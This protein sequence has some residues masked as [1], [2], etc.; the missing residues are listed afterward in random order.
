VVE[1]G[2]DAATNKMSSWSENDFLETLMPLLQQESGARK[3]SCP[4]VETL[5]AVVDGTAG[6]FIREAVA[7]HLEHCNSCVRLH[8]SILLFGKQ[9]SLE[10]SADWMQTEKRLDNWMEGYLR[11]Q[12]NAARRQQAKTVPE[13]LPGARPADSSFRWGKI[14]WAAGLAAVV[15]FALGAVFLYERT[16]TSAPAVQT[17]SNVATSA[18]PAQIAPPPLA[19]DVQAQSAPTAAPP[20][21]KIASANPVLTGQS[22][23]PSAENSPIVVAPVA[24]VTTAPVPTTPVSPQPR[25]ASGTAPLRSTARGNTYGAAFGSAAS[26]NTAHAPVPGPTP[27]GPAS[28][29]LDAGTTLMILL[30]AISPKKEDGSFVFRGTLVEPV[31]QGGAHVG[32]GVEVRGYATVNE[33]KTFVHVMEFVVN[34]TLYTLKGAPGGANTRS[35]GS[36]GALQLE[37]GQVLETWLASVSVYERAPKPAQKQPA[38]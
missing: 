20:K 37:K 15:V 38:K 2:R 24:P 30:N 26:G 11:A 35:P 7:S 14:Q 9:E 31:S 17:A 6:G 29:R 27:V 28:L 1:D 10:Q 34:G 33:G 23:P 32:K 8:Q 13:R 25:P 4:D 21:K 22:M 3:N 5:C 12:T 18:S 16:Q 36:G 19:P